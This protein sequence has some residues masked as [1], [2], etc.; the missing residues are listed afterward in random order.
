VNV[1]IVFGDDEAE[2]L[3]MGTAVAL[4]C[5]LMTEGSICDASGSD[6]DM[7]LLGTL[8]MRSGLVE[9][10]FNAD[11]VTKFFIVKCFDAVNA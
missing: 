8:S 9:T 10:E 11:I 3:V 5:F 6:K 4:D 1:I 2:S 7:I